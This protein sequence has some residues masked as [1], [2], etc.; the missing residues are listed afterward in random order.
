ME[1]T[2][3]NDPL[4]KT[5]GSRRGP[6]GLAVAKKTGADVGGQIPASLIGVPEG[7]SEHP[8]HVVLELH[9]DKVGARGSSA[10]D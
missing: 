6:S 4:D 5:K 7:T 1:Y 8:P 3:V 2:D 9:E 10:L